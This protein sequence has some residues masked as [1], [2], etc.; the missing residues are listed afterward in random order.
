VKR[1]VFLDRDG[2]LNRQ[3][4]GEPPFVTRAEDLVMLPGMQQALQA[5]A[6]MGFMLVVVTNQSGVARGFYTEAELA[7]IHA[8]MH[9]ELAELPVAWFHCPHLPEGTGPYGGLCECRKPRSGLLVQARELLGIDDE[10]SVLVGDSARDLL[11]GEGLPMLRVLVQSGKPWQAELA[12]L[13]QRGVEPDAVLA[14]VPAVAAWLQ[15]RIAKG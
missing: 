5:M 9:R 7:R 13:R 2:T 14:D 4:V 3:E 1:A 15:K 10:G 8:R 6:A 12:T 11:I